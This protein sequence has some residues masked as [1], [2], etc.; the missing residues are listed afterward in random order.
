MEEHKDYHENGQL[1]V[2]CFYQNG[3]LHGEYKVYHETDQLWEHCFYID[4]KQIDP[5]IY[6]E[7]INNITPEEE[8]TLTLVLGGNYFITLK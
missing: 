8:I 5:S 4:G 6:V 2:H 7:D 3:D 1:C